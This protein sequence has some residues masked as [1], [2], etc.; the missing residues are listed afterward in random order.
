MFNVVTIPKFTRTVKVQVPDGDSHVEQSFKA[1][2]QVLSD[3][4]SEG[5]NWS[6]IDGIKAFLRE[7]MISADELVDEKNEPVAF[8]DEIREGLLSLPYVRVALLK[9]Y[10]LAQVQESVGN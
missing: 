10:T 8:S 9:T 1:N 5:L 7:A 2:F 3:D 6:D 4:K